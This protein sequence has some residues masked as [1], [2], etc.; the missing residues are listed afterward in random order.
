MHGFIYI[1]SSYEVGTML[2]QNHLHL[3][4]EEIKVKRLN[5]LP[6]ELEFDLIHFDPKTCVRINIDINSALQWLLR[7]HL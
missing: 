5:K 6:R 2:H 1:K 7:K 4:D 3:K